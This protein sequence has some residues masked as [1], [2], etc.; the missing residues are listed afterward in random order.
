MEVNID[1]YGSITVERSELE[2]DEQFSDFVG[3]VVAKVMNV[4]DKRE[5]EDL[6]KKFHP[7]LGIGGY[8]SHDTRGTAR[9]S[10][11]ASTD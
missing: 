8:E 4:V 3:D 5:K 11:D 1:G 10:P 7:A 2:T 6:T 9:R